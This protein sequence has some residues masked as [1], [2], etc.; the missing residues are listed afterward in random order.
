DGEG[1]QRSENRDEWHFAPSRSVGRT[2]VRDVIGSSLPCLAG[3][4]Q[5]GGATTW[6]RAAGLAIAVLAAPLAA[7]ADIAV[8]SNDAHTVLDN[9]KQIAAPGAPADSVA[10]VDL[11]QYPPKVTATVAAP[12]SVVGPPMAVAVAP[13]ESWAVVTSA[14]K[15]EGGAIVPNDV[16]SVIDLK[17]SPPKV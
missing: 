14:T 3:N 2:S 12:G 7:R 5:T 6:L 1:D 17:S 9:G 4:G 13:D 10:I 15:V 16:V 8:V 11:K